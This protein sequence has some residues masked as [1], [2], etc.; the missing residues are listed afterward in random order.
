M[1]KTLIVE[2]HTGISQ[3]SCSVA[4]YYYWPEEEKVQVHHMIFAVFSVFAF[5]LTY[6]LRRL[7]L[8]LD[9][10]SSVSSASITAYTVYRKHA[11]TVHYYKACIK[12]RQLYIYII[13]TRYMHVRCTGFILFVLN[14]SI[15]KRMRMRE[16]WIFF[17]RP[18]HVDPVFVADRVYDADTWAQTRRWFVSYADM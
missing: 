13:Y 6:I 18:R 10:Y 17:I 7:V 11:W 16:L 14:L 8:F 5:A 12:H 4:L 15:Q 1:N 2:P 3:I 9:L